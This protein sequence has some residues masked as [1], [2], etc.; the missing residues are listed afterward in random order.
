MPILLQVFKKNRECRAVP[1]D[2]TQAGWASCTLQ[3][4]ARSHGNLQQRSGWSSEGAAG[5]FFKFDSPY[6]FKKL[7]ADRLAG[8][9]QVHLILRRAASQLANRKNRVRA[10]TGFES[11]FLKLGSYDIRIVYC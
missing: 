5:M 11:H 9:A 10:G 2:I 6:C 3:F 7:D 8:L 1:E 4:D